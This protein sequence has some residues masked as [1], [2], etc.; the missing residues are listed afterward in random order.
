MTTGRINQVAII[1]DVTTKRARE[2]TPGHDPTNRQPAAA[3]TR[4]WSRR[5]QKC[6]FD[7]QLHC[8]CHGLSD[9]PIRSPLLLM[10]P[11]CFPRYASIRGDA[12]NQTI[13]FR[14]HEMNRRETFGSLARCKPHL[15]SVA[16]YMSAHPQINANCTHTPFT[17]RFG[18]KCD[19]LMRK[20]YEHDSTIHPHP[21]ATKG[22]RGR[23]QRS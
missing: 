19:N 23:L 21:Q 9:L 10:P 11:C 4:E 17:R 6:V 12:R 1:C 7:I 16:S 18:A 2:S 8:R 15:R 20:A 3:H 14:H 13:A 22:L 5:R